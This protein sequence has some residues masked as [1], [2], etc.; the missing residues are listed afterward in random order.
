MKLGVDIDKEENGRLLQIIWTRIEEQIPGMWCNIVYTSGTTGNPKGVMLN[1]DNIYFT[2]LTLMD[3]L[4]H[5]KIEEGKERVVSF[6]PL[7][8]IAAQ[9]F[10]ITINLIYASQLYFARPDALQGSLVETLQHARP[11]MFLGVPRVW[12]KLEERLKELSSQSSMLL[13]KIAAWAKGKGY[14]NAVAK[15]AGKGHPFGYSLAHFLVLGKIKKALG[16]DM[17]KIY[18]VG[19]APIKA[20]TFEY[21]ASLDMPIINI[22][23][24]SESTGPTT[25]SRAGKFKKNTIGYA[26]RQTDLKIDVKGK[27]KAGNDEEGEVCFRGRNNFIG[28]LN[29]DK[30]TKETLDQDGYIHSGDLGVMD[31]DGFVRITGRIKELIITAGGEN[32]APVLI[33]DSLK[34]LCPIISNVMIV[35]DAK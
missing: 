13:Q 24:M 31:S 4:K 5:H 35:G 32:V 2:T 19:A 29:N 1:H 33:E 17:A 25:Y 20:S 12:E 11:T 27:T 14:Q 18:V 34:N 3:E 21:F 30:A 10:D 8:H 7:S 9:V 16:L 23:G 6:L 28:Y 15:M 22:F 26:F